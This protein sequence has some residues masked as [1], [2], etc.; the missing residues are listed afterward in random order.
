MTPM[1][2]NFNLIPA[3]LLE[4]KDRNL[5]IKVQIPTGIAILITNWLFLCIML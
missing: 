2:A 5:L 1:A 4:L 3:Q